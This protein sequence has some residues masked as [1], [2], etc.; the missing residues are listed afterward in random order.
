MHLLCSLF[1]VLLKVFESD[2]PHLLR[3][4]LAEANVLLVLK[5][6][7]TLDRTNVLLEDH[8]DEVAEQLIAHHLD[9]KFLPPPD[10]TREVDGDIIFAHHDQFEPLLLI[11]HFIHKC[12]NA[13]PPPPVK[14][15][16]SVLKRYTG[17]LIPA[18]KCLGMGVVYR[19]DNRNFIIYFA[20]SI[21]D[22]LIS[23]LY[24]EI[25]GKLMS[26]FNRGKIRCLKVLAIELDASSL[27]DSD[28]RS[29]LNKNNAQTTLLEYLDQ[30]FKVIE[31]DLTLNVLSRIG[32]T[33]GGSYAVTFKKAW[34]QLTWATLDSLLVERFGSKAARIFRLTRTKNYVEQEQLQTVSMIPAKEAKLHSYRLLEHNFLQVKELRKATGTG[35]TKSF[36]LFHVDQNQV[37]RTALDL[38]Y[39]AV[40]NMMS[41]HESETKEHR[42]LLEK[43][44]RVKAILANLR[45]QGTTEEQLAEVEGMIT[46]PERNLLEK[47]ET[48]QGKLVLGGLH[49]E[50][51]LF[52]LETF[53]Y[54]SKTD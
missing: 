41:R 35:P 2:N 26:F 46:E 21:L 4:S 45:E 8:G 49:A 33:G 23:D 20:N 44:Q 19:Y 9:T 29:Y 47:V 40:Y 39:K 10:G 52:I 36:F 11:A 38:C 25:V 32:D 54:Y 16:K 28:I 17:A 24:G 14:A 18:V 13:T 22:K 42:R 3:V 53:V 30:Y 50:E 37:V 31:E 51:T 5:F 34:T 27:P 12:C 15:A 48:L 1:L 7:L 6:P 43:Q